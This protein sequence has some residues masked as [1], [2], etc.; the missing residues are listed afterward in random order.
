MDPLGLRGRLFVSGLN[1]RPGVEILLMPA[2]ENLIHIGPLESAG[3]EAGLLIGHLQ[4]LRVK[5]HVQ[6]GLGIPLLG[7]GQI[8]A[9]DLQQPHEIGRPGMPGV[10]GLH[11]GRRFFQC[12]DALLGPGV[13]F[14]LNGPQRGIPIGALAAQPLFAVTHQHAHHFSGQI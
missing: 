2:L 8:S 5:I 6:P 10:L 11:I 3:I 14:L 12:V 1:L 9:R 13:G 4:G 7:W